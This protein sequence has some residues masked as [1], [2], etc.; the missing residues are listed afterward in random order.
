[1]AEMCSSKSQ[2][3]DFTTL[4]MTTE[5]RSLV[6]ITTGQQNTLP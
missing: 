6:P 4:Q 3:S 2:A 5:W 1:M